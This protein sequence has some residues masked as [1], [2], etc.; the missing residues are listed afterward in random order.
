MMRVALLVEGTSAKKDELLLLLVLAL[1]RKTKKDER[2]KDPSNGSLLLHS[3]IK[4]CRG[5]FVCF[6][7]RGS[8]RWTFPK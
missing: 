5:A 3:V 4:K 7:A 2:T 6:S 8:V 1:V